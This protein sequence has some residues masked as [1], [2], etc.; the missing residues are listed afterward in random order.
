M[1]PTSG[2]SSDGQNTSVFEAEP[3]SGHAGHA[4]HA[5]QEGHK[6]GEHGHASHEGHKSESRGA[7]AHDV[8]PANYGHSTEGYVPDGNENRGTHETQA[9]HKAQHAARQISTQGPAGFAALRINENIL[10]AIRDLG[11]EKPT[12]V[13]QQV[14]PLMLQGSDV[15]VQSQT[16]TGK[17]ASFA[18]SILMELKAEPRIQALIVVP[19]RELALQVVEEF[20]EI[21]KYSRF[22]IAPIYG[23]VSMEPQIS[24]VRNGA[25][26]VVATPGRLLDHLRQG[27]ID[28]SSVGFLILDEAD[29]MLDMGFIDDVRQIIQATPQERQTS[30]FSATLP[31]EI[32]QLSSEYL[33]TPESV[34]IKEEQLAVDL[35]KQEYISI[36]PREKVSAIATLLKSRN[37]P[38][39][40]IFCRTKAGADSLERSL[41]S[42]GFNV[43]ALHG[44]L[45][46]ARR[47][48]VMD[49]YRNKR[50]NTL[51]ATDIAARGLDIDDVDLVVNYNLPEDPKI[52]V[53]RIG[54]TAR[55]GKSGM[56]VSF[57][58]NLMEKRFIEDTAVFSNSQINELKLEIDHTL[59]PKFTPRS[60]DRGYGRGG[61]GRGFGGRS[62]GRFGGRGGDRGFGSRGGGYGGD[63]GSLR[64]G[65]GGDRGSGGYR[66]GGSRGGSRGG[67]SS[68][69][70]PTN[71]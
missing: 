59:K 54:R 23:G 7:H 61:S 10:H 8:H 3:H 21:G 31:I 47:E 40:V 4:G 51:V 46:Q 27:T 66:G 28:L 20:R 60:D 38:S 5:S 16:G 69:R 57:V 18:I 56:A 32:A 63:R 53:H 6:S 67:F 39:S 35:I 36:D 43:R 1:E 15:V 45:T 13:Q 52:Y 11:F 70:P 22:A 24:A 29:L 17:T 49:D 65:Y 44:N 19:T 58:T 62:G 25:Q 50:F 41:R 2:H 71:Y 37:S 9:E 42:L 68:R 33:N 14:I 26:V 64:G 12:D 48:R 34:R 55:A 30:L